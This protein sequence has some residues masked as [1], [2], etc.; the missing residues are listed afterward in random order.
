MPMREPLLYF[1]LS[2]SFF[3][4]L[5]AVFLFC[6]CLISS[7]L[8]SIPISFPGSF[9]YSQLTPHWSSDMARGYQTATVQVRHDTTSPKLGGKLKLGKPNQ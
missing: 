8:L 2:Y 5:L 9:F 1:I 4:L 7:L 3:C 6:G